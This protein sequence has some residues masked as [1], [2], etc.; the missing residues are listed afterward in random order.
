MRP[1]T[2]PTEG[3]PRKK[4]WPVGKR[5]RILLPVGCLL[6]LTAPVA[7]SWISIRILHP[8]VPPP[9]QGNLSW[10]RDF[11]VKR[12]SH[13]TPTVSPVSPALGS[14]TLPGVLSVEDAVEW[15]EGWILLDRRLGKIHFLNASSGLTRSMGREGPGPGELKDPV[16]LAVDDSLVWVLNQRGLVLDRYSLISGFQKRLRIRGG[17]CLV[18]LAKKLLVFPTKG[19]FLLRVCPATLP[20]PGTAWVEGIG[21]EGLLAPVLSLPLGEPGSRRLHFLRQPALAG[22]SNSIFMGSWDTPCIGEFGRGGG[23][24]GYRCLPDY[25]RPVTPKEERSNLER[26]FG[27]MRELGLLPIDVPE[28]LPWYDRIFATSR[29]LVVRRIRGVEGRDL[30]LLPPDGRS[31]VTDSLFP[32]GTFV[33]ERSILTVQDLLQGTKVQIFPNPWY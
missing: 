14:F 11:G 16:A 27:R 13:E 5:L 9:P 7:L 3:P 12:A 2:R 6:L 4:R 25:P 21:P 8:P 1:F 18:G 23:L 20:G 26:R 24:E 10:Q 15:E 22:S 30:V 33:G 29:G 31:S 17:G 28:H 32:E 19:L